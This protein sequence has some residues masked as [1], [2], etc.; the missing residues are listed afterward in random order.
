MLTFVLWRF[1][2]CS[3]SWDFPSERSWCCNATNDN[4]TF[5]SG[6]SF[7][8]RNRRSHL[9]QNESAKTWR[10]DDNRGIRELFMSQWRHDFLLLLLLLLF[11]KRMDRF[12]PFCCSTVQSPGEDLKQVEDVHSSLFLVPLLKTK[13]RFGD[14]SIFSEIG[15][16]S[17]FPSLHAFHNLGFP[18]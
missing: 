16:L 3:S 13:W 9:F 15:A 8:Q 18:G 10:S 1:F 7:F 4:A 11:Q 6:G 5:H 17:D 12:H 14:P 2:V